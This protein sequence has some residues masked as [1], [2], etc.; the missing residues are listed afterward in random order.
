MMGEEE[1]ENKFGH[2]VVRNLCWLFS[3]LPQIAY[4]RDAYWA[5]NAL[6]ASQIEKREREG[7][8]WEHAPKIEE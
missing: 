8:K 3:K 4:P 1:S 7:G 5:P 6:P 2:R